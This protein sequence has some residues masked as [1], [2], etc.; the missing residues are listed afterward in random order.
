[1]ATSR[2]SESSSRN[3]VSIGMF[4]KRAHRENRH[5]IPLEWRE[6]TLGEPAGWCQLGELRRISIGEISDN[7]REIL[8][9][10]ALGVV[11]LMRSG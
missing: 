7:G 9:G 3:V 10:D 8:V 2:C 11:L 5:G 4:S 1:M 6:L